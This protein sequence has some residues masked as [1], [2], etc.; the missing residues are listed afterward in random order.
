MADED[1]PV[2]KLHVDG[3]AVDEW[4]ST[5]LREREVRFFYEDGAHG[6]IS[7]TVHVGTETIGTFTNQQPD[8]ELEIEW[9]DSPYTLESRPYRV[10]MPEDHNLPVSISLHTPDVYEYEWDFNRYVPPAYNGDVQ[11]FF[12]NLYRDELGGDLGLADLIKRAR[13][14]ISDPA[15]DIS[16]SYPASIQSISDAIHDR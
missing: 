6:P 3:T 16:L 4:P 14:L 12:K 1:Q 7:G 15:P 8:T 5:I 13:E 11:E 10:R 9:I 2:I